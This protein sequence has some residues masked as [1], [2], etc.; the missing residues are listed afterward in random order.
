ML[1]MW[2][3]EEAFV[4]QQQINHSARHTPLTPRIRGKPSCILSTL[5]MKSSS[6]HFVKVAS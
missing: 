2:K 3:I 1:Q 5:L 6:A 4:E